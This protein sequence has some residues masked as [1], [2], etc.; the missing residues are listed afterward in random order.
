MG[1]SSGFLDV[2]VDLKNDIIRKELLPIKLLYASLMT[3]VYSLYPYL[4]IQLRNQGI[5]PTQLALIYSIIPV[6]TFVAPPFVGFCV[7]KVGHIKV[8]YCVIS[9]ICAV[10]AD[11][12]M[13]IPNATTETKFEGHLPLELTCTG[14]GV[15][16]RGSVTDLPSNCHGNFSNKLNVTATFGY[17]QCENGSNLTNFPCF[18]RSEGTLTCLKELPITLQL[19]NF[20]FT[21]SG[22]ISIEKFDQFV[23][24]KCNSECLS[25]CFGLMR[26]SDVCLPKITYNPLTFW[27]NLAIR[28]VQAIA[29]TSAFV[30]FEAMTLEVLKVQ[31]ADYGHQKLFG[32]VVAC[33]ITPCVGLLVDYVNKDKL[34][35][36]YSICFYIYTA[37][38][39]SSF[40][41]LPFLTVDY[42]MPEKTQWKH[43]KLLAKNREFVG[44]IAVVFFTGGFWGYLE[45]FI[46]L[47]LKELNSPQVVMGLT[48]TAGA[49]AGLPMLIWSGKIIDKIGHAHVLSL[50]LLVY[51]I[52]FLGY[53]LLW[54]PYLCLIFESFEAFTSVLHLVAAS[55]YVAKLAP[56]AILASAQGFF[57][58]VHFGI[59]RGAGNL[60]G[61]YLMAYLGSRASFQ[62]L[63]AVSVVSTIVYLSV[64]HLYLKK[65]NKIT[66][67]SNTG[68]EFGYLSDKQDAKMKEAEEISTKG[69]D[70]TA[71]EAESKS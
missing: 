50:A 10:L 31:K 68:G 37:A 35:I 21:T 29:S 32:H 51:S 18:Y 57:V 9:L 63:S 23:A 34:N 7:D 20:N 15:D 25:K 5:S 36:D 13:F 55:T 22:A 69:L 41:I 2:L 16:V 27:L 65:N 66:C 28:L 53:S 3:A 6:F 33:V 42:K 49:V 1:S 46:F 19:I 45:G 8:I 24:L 58:G 44:F 62:I 54:N 11:C 61:G 56:T 70:N 12:L 40:I 4:T 30:L 71:Y 64:Y 60:V 43:V 38:R 48:V 26:G 14:S 47:F 52:R 17:C 67:D 39:I 59:G